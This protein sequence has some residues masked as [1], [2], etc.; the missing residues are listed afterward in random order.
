M[1]EKAERI[2]YIA[3]II[4]AIFIIGVQFG[5]HRGI[6]ISKERVEIEYQY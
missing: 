1:N 5:I 6:E 4:L 3:L 2:F